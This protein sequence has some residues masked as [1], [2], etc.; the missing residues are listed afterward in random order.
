MFHDVAI[1]FTNE[2][3][4]FNQQTKPICM[5]TVPGAQGVEQD[6]L[7]EVAG[8]GYVD[9]NL[10]KTASDTLQETTLQVLNRSECKSQSGFDNNLI[11]CVGNPVSFFFIF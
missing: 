4:Q 6:D 9:D 10:N 2:E 1:I 7:V 8:W 3:V 5:T 11:F